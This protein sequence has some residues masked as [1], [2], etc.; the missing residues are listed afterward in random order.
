[1]AVAYWGNVTATVQ[2]PSGSPMPSSI[3][4]EF[5]VNYS[6][7]DV[8]AHQGLRAAYVGLTGS[9]MMLLP[10]AGSVIQDG[11][12][13]AQVQPNGSLFASFHVDVPISSSGVSTRPFSV[14]LTDWLPGLTPNTATSIRDAMSVSLKGIYLPDGTSLT[15]DG[16]SVTFDSAAGPIQLET[17]PEPATWAAWG[18]IGAYG[19]LR[20]RRRRARA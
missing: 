1:M 13:P 17:A 4:L 11:E 15:A 8:D 18:L 16:D 19:A 7:S 6:P 14:V 3:R 5:Q 20:L 10:P 9:P 12:Q 2:L